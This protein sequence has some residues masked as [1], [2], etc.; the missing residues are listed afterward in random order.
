MKTAARAR[1]RSRRPRLTAVIAAS[2]PLGALPLQGDRI[3]LEAVRDEAEAEPPGDL[4]LQR[5]DLL[6]AELDHVA[7]G[8]IDEMIVVLLRG[9]FVTRAPAD[10]FELLDDP[11]RLEQF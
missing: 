8:E 3:E 7:G 5:L 10:E 11:L 6:G 1:T 4:R 9:P 2:S